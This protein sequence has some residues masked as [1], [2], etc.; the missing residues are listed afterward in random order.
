[1]RPKERRKT[2]QNDLFK[3]RLDQI[4]D[5]NHALVKLAGAINWSF[6][7]K[8]FGAVYSDGPNHPPPGDEA[9]GGLAILKHTHDLSDAVLCERWIENPCYQLFCGEEFFQYNFLRPLLDDALAAKNGR[10]KARCSYPGKPCHGN[11]HWRSEACR[12]QQ[13]HRRYDGAAEGGDF[14][15]RCETDAQ[16]A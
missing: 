8:N 13:G 15:H 4:A 2:G 1:M 6:L 14:P 3:A 12:L 11:P 16:G 9:Y 10:R 7:E 5:M